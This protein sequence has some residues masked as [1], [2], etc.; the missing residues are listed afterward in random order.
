MMNGA[1]VVDLGTRPW[2]LVRVGASHHLDHFDPQPLQPTGQVKSA[3]MEWPAS[4][5]PRTSRYGDADPDTVR[6]ALSQLASV[7]GIND[8]GQI[9]PRV[10]WAGTVR[11]APAALLHATIQSGG[12]F[13]VM[14]VGG[15]TNIWVVPR[16]APDL[17]AAWTPEV[18]P[19]SATVSVLASPQTAVVEFWSGQKL[20]LSAE[21]HPLTV[22]RFDV[23]MSWV[24]E[25]PDTIIVLRDSKGAVLWT[26]PVISLP[27]PSVTD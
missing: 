16:G 18:G 25:E 13:R 10:I 26:R 5:L 17:P 9:A 22:Q 20:V 24:E 7:I 15:V 14:S 2:H 4:D 8:P 6:G 27:G 3:W 1:L 11:G 12:D 21:A 23:S 19:T